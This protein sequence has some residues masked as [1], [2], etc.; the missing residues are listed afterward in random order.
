MWSFNYCLLVFIGVVGV[1]QLAAVYNNFCCLLFFPVKILSLIFGI[2]AVGMA[3]TGFFFWYD[4]NSIIIEGSQQTGSF[5]ASAAVAIIFTLILSSLVN[6]RRFNS[7][8]P[9]QDGLDTLRQKTFFQ[10]IRN[11]GDKK[12]I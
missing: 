11:N 10:V 3:L 8:K 12:I 5:V 7:V 6:H 2:I 4:L 1:I 9:G